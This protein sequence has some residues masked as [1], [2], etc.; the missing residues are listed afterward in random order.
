MVATTIYP[1][2]QSD[3]SNLADA[4]I[5]IVDQAFS[6]ALKKQILSHQQYKQLLNSIG[7][8]LK[9]SKLYLK[10]ADAFSSFSPDDLQEIEPQTI[11]ELAKH[12]KKYNQVIEKLKDCGK[13]TQEKVHEFIAA[14]RTPKKP[15]PNKPTIWKTGRDGEAV[16]RIPDIM[17]DDMQTGNIIQKE[18]DENGAFPQT[19][20]RKALELW[21]AVQEGKL[22]VQDVEENAEPPQSTTSNFEKEDFVD[23]KKSGIELD[24]N[25]SINSDTNPTG[26]PK[27]CEDG[28]PWHCN[29]DNTALYK[30][31]AAKSTT[32]NTFQLDL[33]DERAL[34]FEQIVETLTRAESWLEVTNTIDSYPQSLKPYIW[35][36]LDT[37][38]Q[39]KF[40]ELKREHFENLNKVLQ[41]NDKVMWEKCPG[42][43]YSWQPFVITRIE[44]GK[45]MLDYFNRPVSLEELTK[46]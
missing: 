23:E 35:R 44:D 9:E 45:A 29:L 42:N 31:E 39:E 5:S 18:M 14:H 26:S 4:T 41:V 12:A 25:T 36:L 19:V 3:I 15:K 37:T 16:C 46:C 32:L 24:L 21:Q 34:P 33:P 8:N 10:V 30:E 7:W 28:C 6:L 22:V 40:H 2:T 1:T 13:I 11:F 27:E 17:E 43:I 20:I 38:T